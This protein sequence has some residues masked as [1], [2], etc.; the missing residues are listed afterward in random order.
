M[1]SQGSVTHWI[2][3]LKAGEHAAVQPL[4]ERY[5][6]RLVTLARA[7]LRGAPRRVADEEDVALSAFDSFCRR[8]KQGRFPQLLNRDELWHLLVVLA[9][10]K[11]V[12]LA[13]RENR[14]KRG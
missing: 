1:S 5:F 8:A 13:R 12:D 3:L 10:R 7:R 4:W 2:S 9:A 14:Q 11:A 6:P